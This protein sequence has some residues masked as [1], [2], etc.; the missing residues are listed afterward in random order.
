[1]LRTVEG[2]GW[3]ALGLRFVLLRC[4][5]SFFRLRSTRGYGGLR[6]FAAVAWRRCGGRRDLAHLGVL[7]GRLLAGF[8]CSLV[9]QGAAALLI[10]LGEEVG[11]LGFL[12]ALEGGEGDFQRLADRIGFGQ[13]KAEAQDKRGMQYSGEKQ[14]KA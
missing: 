9:L 10:I 7:E 13:R 11:F 12:F 4:V 2:R 6:R 5:R 3:R 8:R 1:Q 14:G